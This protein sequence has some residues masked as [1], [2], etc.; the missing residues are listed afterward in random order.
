MFWQVP[1]VRFEVVGINSPAKIVLV[2]M[3]VVGVPL[4][5]SGVLAGKSSFPLELPSWWLTIL[6]TRQDRRGRCGEC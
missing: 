2:G 5:L 6:I 3:T 4:F 1:H